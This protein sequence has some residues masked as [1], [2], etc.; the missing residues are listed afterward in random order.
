MNYNGLPTTDEELLH[1]FVDA[2]S[3]CIGEFSGA[4][5]REL[6]ELDEWAAAWAKDR[7]YA[8][9]KRKAHGFEDTV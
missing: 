4:I 7:G 5:E 6:Q 8:P 1:A 3:G 2:Q 9:P